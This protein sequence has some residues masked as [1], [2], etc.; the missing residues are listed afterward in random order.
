MVKGFALRDTDTDKKIR[1]FVWLQAES[2]VG[3]M[4]FYIIEPSIRENLFSPLMQLMRHIP[5]H[6]RKICPWHMIS[7]F[8]V[9]IEKDPPV[10]ADR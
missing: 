9:G 1:G 10:V 2:S 7:I 5:D 4:T 6:I 8:R 3:I